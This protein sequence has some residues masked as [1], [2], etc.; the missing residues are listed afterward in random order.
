MTQPSASIAESGFD[1]TYVNLGEAYSSAC[2]A[3]PVTSPAWMAWNDALAKQ[4]DWPA[5]LRQTPKA[6]AAL[7]GNDLLAGSSPIATVY[8]GHQFGSYN[9]QL[10]DGRALLLG[11]WRNHAGRRVD[12]QLKGAGPTPFSRGG[13]GRSPVGPV[14]R[15]FLV[16]EA[17]HAL[18]VPTTRA[19]AAV[20]TGDT[21]YRQRPEP[22]AVLTRVA[23]SHLRVGTVQ[24]F[25]MTNAGEGVA[26]LVDYVV[27]RHYADELAKARASDPEYAA[28]RVLLDQTAR[29]FALLVAQWQSLGFIHG[30]L[31]TDN[32]LLCGETVDY[33]PC[34]FMDG[35]SSE[36]VFSSIDTQGRY[37][38][39]NQPGIVH[40]SLSVL[41]QCLL[42]LLDEDQDAALAIAQAAVDQFPEHFS[43]AHSAL[44]AAKFGFQ[45]FGR[46]DQ[47]LAE[48]FFAALTADQLDFT[49]G[50]RWLTE[51]AANNL[52]HTP[53]PELFTPNT[54]LLDWLD[55]WRA[56]K[57]QEKATVSKPKSDSTKQPDGD[58][59]PAVEKMQAVNPAIIPRNHLV[60]RAI[61]EAEAG[62][63]SGMQGMYERWRTPFSWQAGDTTFAAGP[64]QD[65]AV[66]RT[67]CGT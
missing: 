41:A 19:L 65:E 61:S 49:L 38:Y 25:A 8:A 44:L 11:E 50:F 46:D 12:I 24:Y 26:E 21:V 64:T 22:G 53:I 37:A 10:G 6:L 55:D 31:N 34:A 39:R 47:P 59:D 9:P 60:A 17:M 5:A 66:T 30:V 58:V 67:F 52:D 40:W 2:S 3:T 63:Y 33:G 18:G 20:A 1:N 27:A 15:E 7:A 43:A 48:G 57:A 42:P 36:R 45:A 51:T 4:I 14:V 13:D 32:M 16:S 28:A 56:R 29:R 54:Q 23:S 62:D 35:Y